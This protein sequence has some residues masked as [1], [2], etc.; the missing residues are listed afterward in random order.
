MRPPGADQAIQN[1]LAW[2]RKDEWVPLLENIFANHL[3]DVLEDYDLDDEELVEL[4]GPAFQSLYSVIVEDLFSTPIDDDGRTIIDDY[5]KRR[6]WRE[7]VHGRRYLEALRDSTMSLY[8]VVDLDRGKTV[9][10]RDMVRGGDPITVHEKRGSETAALWDRIGARVLLVNGKHYLAGGLLVFSR[11]AGD[12]FLDSLERVMEEIADHP[13]GEAETETEQTEE[14]PLLSDAD[15]RDAVLG[16]T[17]TIVFTRL[18]LTENLGRV[19]GPPPHAVNTDG[20]D[21]VFSTVRFP[22]HGDETDVAQVI[23]G[24]AEID[25]IEPDTVSWSWTGPGSPTQRMAKR[26]PDDGDDGIILHSSDASGRTCLGTLDIENGTL[27]LNT[28]SRERAEKGRDL[29]AAHLKTMVGTPLMTHED[30]QQTLENRP[31]RP[32]SGAEDIPPEVQEQLLNQYFDDYYHQL[33]DE[34]IPALDDK[35]PRQAAS[36]KDDRKTVIDWLKHLENGEQRRAASQGQQPYDFRW[37]WKEL[38]LENER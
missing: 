8:E 28:N 18:W 38:G 13:D 35:T 34:P 36:A 6:G 19:L 9:T 4:L 32:A 31:D 30:I 7:K 11:E 37:M 29:L 20:D 26:D 1:L 3:D 22:I 17:G 25:R 23:D 21:I 14:P 5:L 2:S 33:L 27:I 24:I 16:I 15:L 10:L 12:R